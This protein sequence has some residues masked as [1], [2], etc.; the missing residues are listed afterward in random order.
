MAVV[1]LPWNDI[2]YEFGN[3]CRR[4]KDHRNW[5]PQQAVLAWFRRDPVAPVNLRDVLADKIDSMLPFANIMKTSTA[6]VAIFTKKSI[7]P[8]IGCFVR[9]FTLGS[10]DNLVNLVILDGILNREDR[11]ARERDNILDEQL[12]FTRGRHSSV[13]WI[14][15]KVKRARKKNPE[16]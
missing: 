12:N 1:V 9:S 7:E 16:R 15:E 2:R 6:I 5:A 10:M 4:T 8:T 3:K 13:I 14:G 11:I